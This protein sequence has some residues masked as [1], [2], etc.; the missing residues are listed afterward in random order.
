[1][2]VGAGGC[3]G[4]LGAVVSIPLL[5]G[6]VGAQQTSAQAGGELAVKT[7]RQIEALLAAKEQRTPARRKGS[8]QLLPARQP[9]AYGVGRRQAKGEVV[10]DETV[11]VSA[12]AA[13]SNGQGVT[14]PSAMTLTIT[15]DRAAPAVPTCSG[16][17]AGTYP[18]QQRRPDVVSGF[19]RHWRWQR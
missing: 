8:S 15:H 5:V 16:G 11:M 9:E 1:M 2:P 14:H 19:G 13:A 3:W 10:E 4:L 12:T 7:V 17:M 6:P 18:L